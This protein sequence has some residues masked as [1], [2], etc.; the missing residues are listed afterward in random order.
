[1]TT[2]QLPTLLL[3]METRVNKSVSNALTGDGTNLGSMDDAQ[4]KGIS[5][6]ACAQ[7]TIR[8]IAKNKREVYIGR[9]SYAAYVKRYLPGL[10]ARLIKKAK[11]R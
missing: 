9:E 4:A 8:A 2:L 11:V 6:E 5:A 10:F 7:K 1:M 3:N